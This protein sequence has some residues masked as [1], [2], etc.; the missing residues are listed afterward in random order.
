MD[1]RSAAVL[2]AAKAGEL[3]QRIDIDQHGRLG[4]PEI[5]RRNK[6]LTA[7]EKPR[8]V[9]VFGLELQGLLD[10]PSGDIPE[11]RGFHIVRKPSRNGA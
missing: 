9:A 6:A 7:G 10:G 8:L 11:G 2:D 1:T 4:Q 5:H 3:A